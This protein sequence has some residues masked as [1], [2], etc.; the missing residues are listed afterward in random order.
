[1]SVQAKNWDIMPLPLLQ[2]GAELQL[3][4]VNAQQQQS[5]L[6]PSDYSG[7]SSL[8]R[9]QADVIQEAL[10]REIS[11]RLDRIL[12]PL[13]VFQSCERSLCGSDSLQHALKQIAKRAP[14]VDLVMLYGIMSSSGDRQQRLVV[15]LVDPLS[16]ERYEHFSLSVL[17]EDIGADSPDQ[18]V[19]SQGQLNS[20]S[21]SLGK[22]LS[23][24][25]RTLRRTN[26]FALS[27]SGFSLQELAP[28][29]T[30]M[31]EQ[32][33]E[34]QLVLVQSEKIEGAFAAYLPTVNIRYAVSTKNT[35]SEFNQVMLRFFDQR[36]IRVISEFKRSENRFAL[37]RAGNPYTPSLITSVIALIL[38][39]LLFILLLKRQLFEY[40]LRK[41]ADTKAADQWLK[42]YDKASAP[43]FMLRRKW[44]NQFNYWQ[45]LQRESTELEKQAKLFFEAGDITTTKLFISKALNLNSN[46]Q[47]AHQL[48]EKIDK[49]ESSEKALSEKEQWV[50]NKVAKAMNNYRGNN[51]VKALRQAYQALDQS[52]GEKK[53]KRQHKAIKRLIQKIIAESAQIQVS[54]EMSNLLSNEKAL[55]SSAKQVNIGRMIPSDD[56]SLTITDDEAQTCFFINHKALSRA[57]KQC[58]LAQ[59]QDVYTVEDV[60]STNG[61][62]VVAEGA[63]PKHLAINNAHTLAQG[64]KILLGSESELTAIQLNFEIDNAPFLKVN[65]DEQIQHTLEIADLARVWPDYMQAMRTSLVM[66]KR[67]CVLVYDEEQSNLLLT[68]EQTSKA[69]KR[70]ELVK[71]SLGNKA[72]ITPLN[73]GGKQSANEKIMYNGE[74]LLGEIPMLLPCEIKWRD[75]HIY[76]EPYT[77]LG[78]NKTRSE[79]DAFTLNN[80]KVGPA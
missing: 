46:S 35:P 32:A 70:V 19:I 68:S 31:L 6:L 14:E 23:D 21:T 62:F 5:V 52:S 59:V 9:Y 63:E 57:G 27:L 11:Q 61:T 10:A 65:I 1:M 17:S 8:T 39:V 64:E 67:S 26:R 50:R 42:V 38:F 66:T 71:L 74:I 34:A 60:G 16:F 37:S 3:N 36:D 45:R 24:S 69:S 80:T 29:S 47:L 18:Q 22:M 30:F 28:F 51:A 4:S 48:I 78:P 44:N 76:I 20:L 41:F 25:L 77:A 75:Q 43:W 58:A 7:T 55:I 12:L 79:G 73:T 15:S 72:K 40:Q 56:A 54:I 49:Q 13:S 33:N 2:A 53:L